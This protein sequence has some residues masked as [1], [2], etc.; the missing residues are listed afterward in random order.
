MVLCFSPVSAKLAE[1]SQKF[2]GIVTSTTVDVFDEWPA[3]A[4]Y[5]VAIKE[6]QTVRNSQLFK[7]QYVILIF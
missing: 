3:K 4:M 5:G 6:M 7:V 2:P 1:V